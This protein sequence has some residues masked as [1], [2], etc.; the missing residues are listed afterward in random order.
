MV[1]VI[2][3]SLTFLCAGVGFIGKGIDKYGIKKV[4]KRFK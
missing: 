2:G 1:T 4:N 3:G